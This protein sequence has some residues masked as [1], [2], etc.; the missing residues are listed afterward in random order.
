MAL[1]PPAAVDDAAV[2][3]LTRILAKE[4]GARRITR[5]MPGRL[6][7]PDDIAGLVAFLAGPRSGWV[8]GQVIR[9]NG[10][11]I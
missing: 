5:S 7:Q 1:A 9:A 2:E 8:S 3:T 10:G 11:S 4:L 6:G